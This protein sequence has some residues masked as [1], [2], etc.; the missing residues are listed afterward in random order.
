M[1]IDFTQPK[2]WEFEWPTG[3]E[4]PKEDRIRI[5]LRRLKHDTRRQI[6]NKM[7]SADM[8]AGRSIPSR[9]DPESMTLNFLVGT[10]R[11]IM[12]RDVV[13][14]WENVYTSEGKEVAFSWS[15]F[16]FLLDVNA[17]LDAEKFGRLETELADAID[18]KE[19]LTAQEKKE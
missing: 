14:G 10:V 19:G 11:D 18:A 3:K 9:P 6:E 5:K 7:F 4:F 15:K 17:F 16:T 12:L 8:P 1:K 2:E 13:W